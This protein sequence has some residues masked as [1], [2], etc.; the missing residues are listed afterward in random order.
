MT[1]ETLIFQLY[2][3]FVDKSDVAPRRGLRFWNDLTWDDATVERFIDLVS[4]HAH[5]AIARPFMGATL[6]E[7]IQAFERAMEKH[8]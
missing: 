1:A 7:L 2:W 3:D 8:R 4:L 5:A 6:G